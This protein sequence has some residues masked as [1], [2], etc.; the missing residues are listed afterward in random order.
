M[1]RYKYRSGR[2]LRMK[3][4]LQPAAWKSSAHSNE[5]HPVSLW[6]RAPAPAPPPRPSPFIFYLCEQSI[7]P[8]PLTLPRPSPSCPHCQGG[9]ASRLQ[10]AV[11]W[12][13]SSGEMDALSDS[14]SSFQET[15]P[16]CR[17]FF[18]LCFVIL[19]F[20]FPPLHMPLS[21]PGDATDG[22]AAEPGC[23]HVSPLP[24]VAQSS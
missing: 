15:I 22:A 2:A 14:I 24:H 17:L 4:G 1:R 9:S 7:C 12:L 23:R 19:F 20:F 3:R 8:P 16:S 11:N 6:R 13:R 10:A 21:L 18:L 5:R